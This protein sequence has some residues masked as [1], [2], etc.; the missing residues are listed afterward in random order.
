[1]RLLPS[2]PTKDCPATR[3][4]RKATACIT[5]VFFRWKT[6]ERPGENHAPESLPLEA[7]TTGRPST[8]KGPRVAEPA[9][10]RSDQ[11]TNSVTA[12]ASR[13]GEVRGEVSSRQSPTSGP[14]RAA[15]WRGSRRAVLGDLLDDRGKLIDVSSVKPSAAAGTHPLAPDVFNCAAPSV[16]FSEVYSASTFLPFGLIPKRSV[17]LL[18]PKGTGHFPPARLKYERISSR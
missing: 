3:C 17:S 2:R 1:M 11:K 7:P 14:R 6:L 4:I 13:R 10:G 12:G 9:D 16:R 8:F 5:N 15:E 18:S